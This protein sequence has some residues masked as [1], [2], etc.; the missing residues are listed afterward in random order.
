MRGLARAA[1]PIR[2]STAHFARHAS[3]VA[4][5]GAVRAHG[6][7]HANAQTHADKPKAPKARVEPVTLKALASSVNAGLAAEEVAERSVSAADSSSKDQPTNTKLPRAPS[8]ARV[9]RP[10]LREN[11]LAGSF[12]LKPARASAAGGAGTTTR[13]PRGFAPVAHALRGKRAVHSHATD[14]RVVFDSAEDGKLAVGPGFLEYAGPAPVGD[15]AVMDSVRSVITYARLRDA[16]PCPLCIHPTTR[17]KTHTSGEARRDVL[18]LGNEVVDGTTMHAATNADGRRGLEVHWPVETG[19]PAHSSFYPL[20][21]IRRLASGQVRGHT[22]L[23]DTMQRKLW[24]KD[25]LVAGAKDLHIDYAELNAAKPGEP[26]AANPE[27]LLRLLEQLHTYG[28]VVL[29]GVPTDKTANK[30]CE[31]RAVGEQIGLLRNTF[32]GETW[33]V[34][35]VVN[36]KNVAY[37]NLNLGLHMDLL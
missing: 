10:M 20:S 12:T 18:A 26:L 28:L 14:A 25:S 1:A 27:V 34:K 29:R 6:R 33:D 21:L 4:S 15:R 32:Y 19:A 23:F 13:V 16:C 17:Q 3:T 7:A 22:F 11:K 9:P 35:S 2:V 31:L 37:T 30:E 36:S 5:S 8:G 24:D